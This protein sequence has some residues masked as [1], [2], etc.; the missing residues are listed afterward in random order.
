M[1][2]TSALPGRMLFNATEYLVDRHLREGRAEHT[3]VIAA[4]G[5][6]TYGELAEQVH[7]VASGLRELGVR[8]E[9]RVMLC[10][11]DDIEMLT[12][13]LA[14]MYLGAI[15]APVSTMLTASELAKLIYDS[16][17]RIVCASAEFASAV[18]TA[19]THAP[20]VTT[21]IVDRQA[22]IELPAKTTMHHWDILL[23]AGATSTAYSTWYDSPALWLYTSGTTGA[24]KAAMH[25]H[26]SIRAVAESYG[27]GVLGI[28][29][30]DCCLSVAKMFFAY[31]LGNSCFLPLSVGATSV[32]QRVRPT[33]EAIA[34]RVHI[35]APT[36]LFGVPT[37][38]ASVLSSDVPG[39][40]F[41]SVRQ[42]VSAGEPLPGPVFEGFRERFG[43]EVLDGI[44]STEALHIFL[45]NR[46]NQARPGS[47]GVPVPGYQ[48][49]LRDDAG[50]V[51]DAA[52]Q[53]GTL[54]VRGKSIA[55]GYWCQVEASRQ[56][57]DGEWLCTGDAY[58]RNDDD[59]HSCLGRNTDLLKPGGIWLA[60]VEVEERL[61]THPDVAEAAVVAA[62][63]DSGLEKPVAC[64]VLRAGRAID[65]ADLIDW[66]RQGLAAFKRPRAVVTMAELPKTPTGKV[67]RSQLRTQVAGVLLTQHVSA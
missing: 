34:E 6:L 12:G 32:L 15:A 18:A 8:P 4:G 39:D 50:V 30:A 11:A 37:F 61:L 13:I 64:I 20:E 5:T 14:A 33:V 7:R 44:G 10:M 59:T 27:A 40:A 62:L 57:F 16:R 42:G 63:D 53:I 56:V 31:G 52:G 9:E 41:G 2:P 49:Q 60:P 17:A 26:G 54:Y 3:A 23:G 1:T 48:V 28:T 29:E 45:S 21:V 38:Y 22:D 35:G 43:V 67:L 19:V 55:T 25:R 36:L 46:P 65:A 24:P 51:I 47:S 66:C 58:I